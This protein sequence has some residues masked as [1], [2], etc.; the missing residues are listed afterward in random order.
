MLIMV[1]TDKLFL[2]IQQLTHLSVAVITNLAASLQAS[3][4]ALGSW[5]YLVGGLSRASVNRTLSAV[6]IVVSMAI[7]FGELSA[8]FKSRFTELSDLCKPP[9]LP[10]DVR[11]S[12][13]Y[14]S[15]E[16]KLDRTICCPKCFTQYRL[17]RIPENCD[18]RATP[19]SRVCDEPLYTVRTTG[20]GPLRVPC[21]LYNVQDFEDWLEYFLS[22]PGIED[23]I[24]AS[25]AHV[26]NATKMSSI[27]DSPAWRS[28][29][30]FTT[31]RGNL[32]F[33]YFIDWF[34]P[35]TNKIAGKT[36]SAGAIMF[37][38]LNLPPELQY[39]PEYTYF[40]AITPLPKEP[41]MET[42]TAV[43]DP[44]ISQVERLWAGRVLRSYRYPEGISR[45]VGVLPAIGDLLAMRKALGFAGVGS[46]AHFCS[47]CLLHK[48]N[49][50]ETDVRL[51][52]PRNGTDVRAASEQWRTATTKKARN[53][54][55]KAHGVRWSSLHTLS[56]RD[57]VKH[58]VL[59]LMH[60]WIEGVL[61]HHVRH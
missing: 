60:N 10:R 38:C 6:R 36:V 39:R 45:R 22:I 12:M 27:W 41:D 24:D 28:L 52:I 17:S 26:P 8:Q 20:A 50:E 13:K 49:I 19:R 61:Q 30:S 59:G 37:F 51:F 1:R 11:T 14:L 42:I 29:G 3:V 56:Y 34:N 53:E 48:H 54:I 35:L 23:T 7:K 2:P 32:T 58:T 21:R 43:S 46:F 57:P 44:V 25:Y 4:S 55:F 9:S 33:S 18:F 15:I 5:L 31:T 40:A 47:F 16:P